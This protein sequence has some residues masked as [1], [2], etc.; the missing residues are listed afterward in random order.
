MNLGTFTTEVMRAVTF[1]VAQYKKGWSPEEAYAQTR[2]HYGQ[3]VA[4]SVLCYMKEPLDR[5]SPADR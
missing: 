3:D 4:E 5:R 2:G 1:F